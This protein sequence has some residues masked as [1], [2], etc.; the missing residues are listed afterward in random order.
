MR[1]SPEQTQRGDKTLVFLQAPPPSPP[2]HQRGEIWALVGRDLWE[3]GW[4]GTQVQVS[5]SYRRSTRCLRLPVNRSLAPRVCEHL[6][7]LVTPTRPHTAGP[8][9]APGEG[10]E[11]C[12]PEVGL[13]LGALP[14]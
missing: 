12:P 7:A 14:L 5:F 10:G 6:P 11:R 13:L 2:S 3:R 4:L 1:S 9:P 8:E